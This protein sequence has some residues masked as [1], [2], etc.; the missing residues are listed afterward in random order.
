MLISMTESGEAARH[1]QADDGDAVDE[2]LRRIASRDK[3]AFAAL[4]DSSHRASSD[5]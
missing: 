4:Y 1:A 2:L 5:S 3:G